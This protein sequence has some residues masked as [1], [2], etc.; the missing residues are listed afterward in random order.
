MGSLNELVAVIDLQAVVNQEKYNIAKKQLKALSDIKLSLSIDKAGMNEYKKQLKSLTD[1]KLTVDASMQGLQ[2]L[3]SELKTKLIDAVSSDLTTGLNKGISSVDV[4]KLSED[5]NKA[6]SS[7]GAGLSEA[8]GKLDT[9]PLTDKL[10]A[11]TDAVG[12]E[13]NKSLEKKS[14]NS[15]KSTQGSSTQGGVGTDFKKLGEDLTRSLGVA[16]LGVA[17]LQ[18][19]IQSAV[20]LIKSTIEP[21]QQ[22]IVDVFS[23]LAPLFKQ[24]LTPISAALQPLMDILVD[25]GAIIIDTLSPFIK[26]IS[27]LFKQLLKPLM[28]LMDTLL[29]VVSKL[30]TSFAPLITQLALVVVQLLPITKILE[31]VSAGIE[32]A[33]PF[34]QGVA[35]TLTYV[36]DKISTLANGFIGKLFGEA[37]K[38]ASETLPTVAALKKTVE[39]LNSKEFLTE[40]QQQQLNKSIEQLD[41][42]V[43]A[44]EKSLAVKIKQYGADSLVVK[45]RRRELEE[46]KLQI[47]EYKKINAERSAGNVVEQARTEAATKQNTAYKEQRKYVYDVVSSLERIY[48]LTSSPLR[49]DFSAAQELNDIL[50]QV[51]TEFTELQEQFFNAKIKFSFDKGSATTLK[52][53]KEEVSEFYKSQGLQGIGLEL[54]VITQLLSN[55]EQLKLTQAQLNELTQEQLNLQGAL[56]EKYDITDKRRAVALK[57]VSG[58]VQE[59]NKVLQ[60]FTAVSE[61]S[62][63]YEALILQQ[64]KFAE[65]TKELEKYLKEQTDLFADTEIAKELSKRNELL[66]AI[67]ARTTEKIIKEQ[68][69]QQAAFAKTIEDVYSKVT[70]YKFTAESELGR[71]ISSGFNISEY[72]VPGFAALSD[73]LKTLK[74]TIAQAKTELSSLEDLDVLYTQLRTTDNE[75][76]RLSIEAKIAKYKEL[77]TVIANGTAQAA[78]A[79]SELMKHNRASLQQ[80][81]GFT[82]DLLKGFFNALDGYKLKQKEI[83]QAHEFQR[84]DFYS[85]KSLLETNLAAGLLS[86]E[87]YYAKLNELELIRVQAQRDSARELEAIHEEMLR[88]MLQSI[89]DAAIDTISAYYIETVTKLLLASAEGVGTLNF[90]KVI[91]AAAATA[92]IAGVSNLAKGQL[93]SLLGHEAGGIVKPANSDV[94]GKEDTLRWLSYGEF[95][96]NKRSATKYA[97]VLHDI[98]TG[99]YNNSTSSKEIVNEIQLMRKELSELKATELKRNINIKSYVNA[100]PNGIIRAI[101]YKN[102]V[103]GAYN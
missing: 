35:N 14:S 22:V 27:D 75:A 8:L 12:T 47:I 96:V 49:F 2:E 23:R 28:S 45:N 24:L 7:V 13:I 91:A 81:T 6:V 92:A 20:T 90:A 87:E 71:F 82:N 4:T 62:T 38:S 103:A 39:E 94:K 16:A 30:L 19:S 72:L 18:E 51:T 77:A 99:T 58:S 3:R 86:Y 25:V 26:V 63:K 93:M 21:V 10:K 79:Q 54:K 46:L 52:K 78:E 84:E 68:T 1:V 44:Q 57:S 34:L 66:E 76:E 59:L 41:L 73:K 32:R 95:V 17:V 50:V 97:D 11:A 55:S 101:K 102:S 42:Q 74:S 100:N 80:I 15:S 69:E 83:Y 33:V 60:D 85:D 37:K 5:L 40:A 64:R 48:K 43:A 70:E 67:T 31:L 98:N 9:K 89:I 88:S 61:Y 56:L 36:I 65:E 53:F 29:P